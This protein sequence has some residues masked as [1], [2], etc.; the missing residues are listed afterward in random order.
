MAAA[1]APAPA[2]ADD[3]RTM[4]KGDLDWT[5]RF[6]KGKEA[7]LSDK[8]AAEGADVAGKKKM[9]A[10]PTIKARR[11]AGTKAKPLRMQGE[12]VKWKKK[13]EPE[14]QGGGG[15]GGERAGDIAAALPALQKMVAELNAKAKDGS[16]TVIY[17]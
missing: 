7:G 6:L 1:A 10:V 5:M 11:P 8:D 2:T 3:A 17:S 12:E 9:A 13:K 4:N 14:G 15:G 16:K